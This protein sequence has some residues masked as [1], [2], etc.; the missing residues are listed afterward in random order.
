MRICI[1][2]AAVLVS[3]KGTEF[4]YTAPNGAV[5]EFSTVAN[6][7]LKATT[8]NSTSGAG[9]MSAVTGNSGGSRAS[10]FDE[11]QAPG[12][13][14][15]RTPDGLTFTM[16]GATDHSTRTSFIA[17]GVTNVARIVGAAYTAVKGLFGTLNNQSDNARDVDIARSNNETT[18]AISTNA[19]NNAVEELR[20]KRTPIE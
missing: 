20:I 16:E 9:L 3:C 11:T 5:T 4:K 2:A 18:E 8:N 6:Q 14:A 15:M 17:D 7:G 19:S 1:L 13:I 10:S 12:R